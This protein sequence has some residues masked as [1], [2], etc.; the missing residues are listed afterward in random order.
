MPRIHNGSV[1]VSHTSGET[2][3]PKRYSRAE[4]ARETRFPSASRRA[5]APVSRRLD[6][7]QGQ[8]AEPAHQRNAGK[9]FSAKSFHTSF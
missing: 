4:A 8:R 6:G 3:T 5:I 9:I 2:S 1:N 7:H